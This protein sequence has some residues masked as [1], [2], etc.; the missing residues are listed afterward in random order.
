[1]LGSQAGSLSIWALMRRIPSF[2]WVMIQA[3]RPLFWRR[4]LAPLGWVAL[5]RIR[6]RVPIG[7]RNTP[8]LWEPCWRERGPRRKPMRCWIATIVGDSRDVRPGEPRPHPSAGNSST[9]PTQCPAR[10]IL[11]EFQPEGDS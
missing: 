11:L 1:M 7:P 6:R 3:G 2:R 4:L 8:L 5:A 10:P 9:S